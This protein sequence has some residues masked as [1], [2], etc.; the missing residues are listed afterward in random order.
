MRAKRSKLWLF[1]AVLIYS[2]AII[3]AALDLLISIF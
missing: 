3:A 2:A 1:Y